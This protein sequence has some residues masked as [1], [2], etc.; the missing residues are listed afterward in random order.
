[1]VRRW[2]TRLKAAPPAGRGIVVVALVAGIAFLVVRLV[3]GAE[4]F[5]AFMQAAAI[6]FAVMVLGATGHTLLRGEDL[7]EAEFAGWRMKFS[8][9]R[10]AVGALERRL[11][12][13]TKTT[14]ERLLRL[15]KQVFPGAEAGTKKQE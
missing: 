7:E 5:D 10:R 13:H 8:A 9:A 11:D 15:E 1:M 2:F 3:Q 4:F 14:D 12:A 6:A